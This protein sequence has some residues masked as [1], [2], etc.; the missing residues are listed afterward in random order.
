MNRMNWVIFLFSIV[1]TAA[2]AVFL[3]LYFGPQPQKTLVLDSLEKQGNSA[4]GGF[5]D[6]RIE[7]RLYFLSSD[8]QQLA[9][10]KREIEAT[11]VIKTKVE[12]AIREWLKGPSSSGLIL[13]AP[14]G[15]ELKS[16]FWSDTDRRMYLNFSETLL[17]NAPGH[18]LAEWATIYGLVNTAA[19]QS[20]M[21]QEVQLLVNGE[22]VLD[23][24]TVWDWSMPF[25]P[26]DA[27]V[28]TP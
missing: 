12:A 20:P 9:V 10:E 5:N 28:K 4:A 24:H 1:T 15:T 3:T 18:V 7:T 2:I 6:D 11:T 17:Q 26:N 14:A 21:I 13:P 22:P 8:H 19:A 16:V 25:E 23:E 27:L